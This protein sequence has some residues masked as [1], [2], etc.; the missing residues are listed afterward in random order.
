MRKVEAHLNK[1]RTQMNSLLEETGQGGKE[2]EL[3]FLPKRESSSLCVYNLNKKTM[4][5]LTVGF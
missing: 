1:M 5:E 4:K 3:L 2:E